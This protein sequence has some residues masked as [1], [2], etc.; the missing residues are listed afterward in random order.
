MTLSQPL[1]SIC[2]PTYNRAP[3]LRVAL[4]SILNQLDAEDLKEIIE[5]VVSDN[6][7]SDSTQSL[8]EAYQKKYSQLKYFRNSENI[9]GDLNLANSVVKATGKFAWY[10]G[11]DDALVPGILRHTAGIL[12]Q[13]NPAVVGVHYGVLSDPKKVPGNEFLIKD[14]APIVVEKYQDFMERGYCLGI[15]SVILFDRDLWLTVDHSKFHTLWLYYE[16]V[17]KLMSKAQ[18]RKFVYIDQIGVLTGEGCGWVKNGGELKSFLDWREILNSL[19]DYGYNKNWI[20]SEQKNF[21]NLLIIILLRAKGHDLSMETKH[22]RRVYKSFSG[23]IFYLILASLIF[24]LPNFIIKAV[25]NIKNLLKN[26]FTAGL[27]QS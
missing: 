20:Q 18:G 14:K 21:P 23:R 15:L 24:Y 9:G 13:H 5:V 25:R 8:V 17:L 2:I 11:D 6:A 26:F 27:P 16:V 7:S 19:S 3:Q 12:K 10:L 22:L 4:D 1:L